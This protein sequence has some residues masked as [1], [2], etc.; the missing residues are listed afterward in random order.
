MEKDSS[1]A[2][3]IGGN[4]KGSSIVMGDSNIVATGDIGISH[5]DPGS[6]DIVEELDAIRNLIIKS[7]KKTNDE[8]IQQLDD[9]KTEASKSL[10]DKQRVGDS[11]KSVLNYASGMAGVGYFAERLS[12]HLRNIVSW[13]GASWHDLLQIIP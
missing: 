12:P 5:P 11:V 7:Q 8:I 3:S 6:F 2:I 10:P 9:A 13:L 4:V 1:N